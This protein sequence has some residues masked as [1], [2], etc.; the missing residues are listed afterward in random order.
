MT[1]E[2]SRPAAD[3][4]PDDVGGVLG[5]RT[6]GAT[7][8]VEVPDQPG[9]EPDDPARRSSEPAVPRPGGLATGEP[10]WREARRRVGAAW[11]PGGTGTRI[12]LVIGG[13]AA[14][15]LLGAFVFGLWHVVVGGFVKG[16]WNAGGFGI[17]L[18]SVAG[19]LL[20]IEASIARRLLPPAEAP[21]DSRS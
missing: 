6:E 3:G 17:A 20:W 12:T 13:M 9:D 4:V 11:A 16:N 21:T 8:P 10:P 1:D 18:A 2:R 14:A 5:E 19:V 15:A 7:G